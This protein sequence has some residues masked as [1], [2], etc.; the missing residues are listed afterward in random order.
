[1]KAVSGDEGLPKVHLWNTL[2]FRHLCCHYSQ[3]LLAQYAR[4][5]GCRMEEHWMRTFA[6]ENEA[7]LAC[8]SV[9]VAS[10]V[11]GLMTWHPVEDGGAFPVIQL[12]PNRLAG[13]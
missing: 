7:S 10:D 12:L 11:S 8:L 13:S 1:M 5:F 6:V 9:A 4:E 3:L 2:K